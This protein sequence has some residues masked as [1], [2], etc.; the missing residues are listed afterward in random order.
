MFDTNF[1]VAIVATCFALVFLLVWMIVVVPQRRARENQIAV[2][3]DL[4]V[5]EKVV[6][7]GG[8]VG[9]LTYL[10]RDEDVA[11]MELTKGIEVEVIPSAISHPYDYMDRVAALERRENEKSAKKKNS[12]AR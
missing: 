1:A 8:L 6:T 5:G 12:N 4:K 7:V 9:R 11:R 10:N 2:L 3:R